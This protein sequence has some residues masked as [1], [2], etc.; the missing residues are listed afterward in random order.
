M[1]EIYRDLIIG[2]ITTVTS[3]AAGVLIKLLSA[4]INAFK[5]NT[6]EK[7][8][9]EFFTW[10]ECLV[11]KCINT[12]TQTYVQELKNADGFDVEAQKIALGK[13]IDNVMTLLTESNTELL[14]SYVGDITTWLTVYIE[15]YLGQ[16]KNS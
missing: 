8:K 7:A 3:C 2:I 12:T 5:A 14:N 6:Q 4:K 1:N 11:D 15:D 10:L 9:R 16:T 13:T